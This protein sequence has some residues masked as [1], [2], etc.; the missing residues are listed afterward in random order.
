VD[1]KTSEDVKR[2]EERHRSLSPRSRETVNSNYTTIMQAITKIR[3]HRT[4]KNH[5]NALHELTTYIPKK[6]T[7]ENI[8]RPPYELFQGD[9]TFKPQRARNLRTQANLGNIELPPKWQSDQQAKP[10]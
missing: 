5:R 9:I 1:R 10:P 4:M 6:S 3:T 2:K 8:C 7:D